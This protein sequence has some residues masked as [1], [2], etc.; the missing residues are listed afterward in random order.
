MKKTAFIFGSLLMVALISCNNEEAKE[1]EEELVVEPVEEVALE[2]TAPDAVTA[3]FA[4]QF[5]GMQ[6]EWE[7]EGDNE[8]EAEFTKEGKEYSAS[9]DNNGQWLATE[10]E[11]AMTDVPALV[12]AAIAK[13]FAG[14]EVGE[15]EMVETANGMMFEFELKKGEEELEVVMDATGKVVKQE[16]EKETGE[17][18]DED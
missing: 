7:Q 14:Y 9:Y 13:Q 5:P 1:V 6:A 8:W 18:A 2:A 12:K 3:A 15:P 4:A 11:I 17:E 10:H 16:V